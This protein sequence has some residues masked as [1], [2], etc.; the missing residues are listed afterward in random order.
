[1][2]FSSEKKRSD[3]PS[4]L[5]RVV[6]SLRHFRFPEIG[7]DAGQPWARV[8]AGGIRSSWGRLPRL[9]AKNATFLAILRGSDIT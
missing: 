3:D 8:A 7:E 1:M 6:L 4:S 5:M 2:K 9:D